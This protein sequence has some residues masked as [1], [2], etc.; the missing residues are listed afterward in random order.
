VAVDHLLLIQ[1]TESVGVTDQVAVIPPLLIQITES[2]GVSDQ[3]VI[4]TE[5]PDGDTDGD[6]I[7]NSVDTE[8]STPSNQ[9]SDVPLAGSTFGEIIDSSEQN[10]GVFDAA[11]NAKGVTITTGN[12]PPDDYAVVELCK[13]PQTIHIWS[14]TKATFTCGSLTVDVATGLVT[15]LTSDGAEIDIGPGSSLY[16]EDDG[17]TVTVE[18][19]NGTAVLR[20]GGVTINLQTGDVVESPGD[21]DF[22]HDSDG[23]STNEETLTGTDPIDPD[24]DGDGLVDGIDPTWLNEYVVAL[25]NDA[26]KSA[27]DRAKLGQ[28]LALVHRQVSSGDRDSALDLVTIMEIRTNGCGTK[29]DRNDW[30]TDCKAQTEFNELLGLLKRNIAVMDLPDPPHWWE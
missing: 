24:T 4:Q 29:A 30:I 17:E 8:P 12:D 5:D 22:D 23:L 1:I 18:V 7:A 26:F 19:L 20:V 14:N 13:E 16:L 3:I 9:F 11:D 2:V 28:R 21:T 25:P 10:V 6:G 15:L 27:K